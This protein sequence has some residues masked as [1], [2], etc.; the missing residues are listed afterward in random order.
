MRKVV[1]KGSVANLPKKQRV[2]VNT[3]NFSKKK[4]QGVFFSSAKMAILG[5]QSAHSLV[6]D[7]ALRWF[8]NFA[9]QF[10]GKPERLGFRQ[11][12]NSAKIAKTNTQNPFVSRTV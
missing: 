1:P 3:R 10:K 4:N 5:R 7:S 6:A 2:M 8:P 9:A 12:E 11:A